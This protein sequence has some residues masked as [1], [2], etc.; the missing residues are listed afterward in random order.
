[1]SIKEA[2]LKYYTVKGRHR[3][4]VLACSVTLYIRSSNL[5]IERADDTFKVSKYPED[6]VHEL[7]WE[8]KVSEMEDFITAEKQS[9]SSTSP[10]SC[11][12]M[13]RGRTSFCISCEEEQC[14]QSKT[15]TKFF[16]ELVLIF[17]LWVNKYFFTSFPINSSNFWPMCMYMPN[18]WPR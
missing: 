3:W 14:W 17:P 13:D 2:S 16:Y 8:R 5:T 12:A 18:A 7:G 9:K 10:N 4:G 1:M 6:G 15:R 11:V